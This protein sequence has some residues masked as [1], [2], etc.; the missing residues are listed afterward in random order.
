MTNY[1]Y[2]S[3]EV[4]NA[5]PEL[6]KSKPFKSGYGFDKYKN[7]YVAIINDFS[8]IEEYYNKN[9]TKDFFAYEIVDSLVSLTYYD[10]LDEDEEQLELC[11][12]DLND[13][14]V[15]NAIENTLD[16]TKEKNVAYVFYKLSQKYN[17]N[18]IEL[19]NKF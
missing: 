7:Y 1:Y 11:L 3:E 12:E 2:V 9:K 13:Y 17:L 15:L 14:G 18:P 6:E 19:A 5:F 16:L 8:V 10:C 4:I